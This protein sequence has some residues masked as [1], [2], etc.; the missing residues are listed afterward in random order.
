MALWGQG[1]NRWIVNNLED[2]KNVNS[3][4]WDEIKIT[5]QFKEDLGAYLI[6][7]QVSID[8]INTKIVF[9]KLISF[10]GDI[11]MIV[12]RKGKK[13]KLSI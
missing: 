5:S 4:H 3:R 6:N 7:N 12:N 11:I 1:D 8:K 9:S 13:I 10:S 2:G